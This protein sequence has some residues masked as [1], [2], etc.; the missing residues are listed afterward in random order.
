[1]RCPSL[2]ELPLPPAGRRGWPWTEA[3]APLPDRMADGAPWPRISIVTPSF[4]Q[5]VFIEE[6]IRSVLLQG[7][8]DV[9]Y[10]IV[11]GGSTD[12]SVA[13]IRKYEPWLASWVSEHDRGQ[14]H[15]INK[16]LAKATGAMVGWCNSD[17]VYLPLAFRCLATLR[18]QHPN[19][20]GWAGRCNVVSREGVLTGCLD[21][22]LGDREFMADWWHQGQVPQPSSLFSAAAWRQA[23]GV[24]EALHYMMDAELIIRLAG[25]GSFAATTEVTAAFRIYPEAKTSHKTLSGLTELVAADVN[26]NMRPIAERILQRHIDHEKGL[27]LDRLTAGEKFQLLDALSFRQAVGGA[28]RYALRRTGRAVRKVLGGGPGSGPG[29]TV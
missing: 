12:E 26:L 23:G 29:R 19:A 16:G 11:D 20:V 5:G 10:S 9:E 7:Y 15:A 2:S 1:M 28:L 17:D 3:C 22:C 14:S 24:N 8:P 25:V 13:I 4:N 21:V 6:T 18:G 27:A